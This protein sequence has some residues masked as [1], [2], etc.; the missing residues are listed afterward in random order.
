MPEVLKINPENPELNLIARA[1]R[2]LK[3][4]GVIAFPTET[5]YGL[6]ADATNEDAVEEIFH[7]KGRDFSN[8]VALIIGNDRQ[9]HGLVEEIPD[10]GRILMQT[11]WPGPLTLVFKASPQII[12][13]LTAHTGKIGIRI[14]SHP[15]AACLANRLDRPITATSA[16][17]SGTPEILS[18]QEV[19]RCLG[20]RVDLVID[21]GLSPGGK[22]STIF[23]IT[24]DPP[25]TLREGAIPT[26]LIREKL[27]LTAAA[28]RRLQS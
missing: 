12:P 27:L 4:G 20:D 5:F 22:G 16:N 17:F 26:Q 6:A 15:V 2:I 14:S 21:G 25:V 19:V 13:K 8:P 18:P 9:L 3:T 7:L 28:V 1:I 10:I 11:F 23:D 24:L